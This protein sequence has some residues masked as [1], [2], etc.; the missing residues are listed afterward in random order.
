MEFLSQFWSSPVAGFIVAF[1]V[2]LLIGVER[3]RRKQDPSVGAA[4]GIRTHVIVA[5]AG[6]L[7]VH[8]T[9]EFP[10]GVRS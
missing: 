2:G 1:A 8:E 6:A 4:G 3:E 10:M 5:L 9:S 7:A